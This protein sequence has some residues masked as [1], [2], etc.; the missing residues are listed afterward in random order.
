[1]LASLSYQKLLSHVDDTFV[2]PS[3]TIEVNNKLVLNMVLTS[4]L[5]LDQKSMILLNSSL[6]EED[7]AE[8]LG[9]ST[10]YLIWTS[11]ESTYNSSSVEGIHSLHDS[12]RQMTKGNS[13]I[14]E[15]GRKFTSGYDKLAAIGQP[16]EDMDKIH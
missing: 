6:T 1:M 2:K 13:T 4:W 3:T 12:L 8:V 11:S 7:V 16:V 10:T 14:L 9:L 15:Y 5:D